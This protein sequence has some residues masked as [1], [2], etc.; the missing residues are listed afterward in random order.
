MLLVVSFHVSLKLVSSSIS[1]LF[2][3]RDCGRFCMALELLFERQVRKAVS[4]TVEARL[5]ASSDGKHGNI[6]QTPHTD[7]LLKI[8]P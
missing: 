4:Q 2:V 7:F 1:R 5:L 6:W 3:V 8:H